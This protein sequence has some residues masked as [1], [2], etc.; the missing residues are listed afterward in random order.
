VKAF[1]VHDA[2][3]TL[4]RHTSTREVSKTFDEVQ[5]KKERSNMNIVERWVP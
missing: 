5:Q 2:F 4:P 1:P 3:M